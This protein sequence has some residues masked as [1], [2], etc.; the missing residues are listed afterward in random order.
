MNLFKGAL[1][2][3]GHQSLLASMKVTREENIEKIDNI[4]ELKRLNERQLNNIVNRALAVKIQLNEGKYQIAPLNHN[5]KTEYLDSI[6]SNQLIILFAQYLQ[7]TQAIRE[8]ADK[9]D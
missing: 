2:E 6:D 9:E 5:D 4:K 3:K 8:M 7:V 1:S